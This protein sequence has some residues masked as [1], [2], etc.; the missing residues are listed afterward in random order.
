MKITV[1]GK[2]MLAGE[3]NVLLPNHSCLAFAITRYAHCSIIP[4]SNFTLFSEPF[5]YIVHFS[6]EENKLIFQDEA[7]PRYKDFS[8]AL[9]GVEISLQYLSLCNI[10]LKPFTLQV[11]TSSFYDIHNTNLLKI[12]LGSSAASLVGIVTSI[13]VFHGISV[14]NFDEKLIVF[15]LSSIAL[16]Y[17]YPLSSCY[18]LA[19]CIFGSVIHY[20][21]FDTQLLL[22]QLKENSLQEVLSQNFGGWQGLNITQLT[23]REFPFLIYWTGKSSS[24]I[25]LVTEVN[26]YLNQHKQNKELQTLYLELMDT[27]NSVVDKLSL[28]LDR[29]DF[30]LITRLIKKNREL[31]L[32]FQK[33]ITVTLETPDH[34]FIV[35]KAAKHRCTAKLSGAGG[36]DIVIVV[37]E[38]QSLLDRLKS[39][40]SEQNLYPLSLSLDTS[41]VSYE[42]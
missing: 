34:Q 41:G 21:S 15:K 32:D 2:V 40:L 6:F 30:T 25:S 14:N 19:A 35:T 7:S 1:P 10:T 31:L 4:S 29:K 12:G 27:I 17:H 3:W 28:A 9:K 38:S 33:L 36:G 42:H 26:S 8:L 37:G 39:S 20:T 22:K 24:T 16:L 23:V 18:D 5:K 13:L 11:D